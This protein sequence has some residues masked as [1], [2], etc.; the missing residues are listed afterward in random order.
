[1]MR[2][3]GIDRHEW[4]TE[5]E[6]LEDDLHSAP[7]EALP[8]LHDLVERML[9]ARGFALHEDPDD[10]AFEAD[11]LRSFRG[12]HEVAVQVE[13][14]DD[15][16]PGDVGEAIHAFTEIYEQLIDRPDN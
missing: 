7:L 16:D 5:W 15:V 4:Q 8:E 6:A 14:G 9:L 2:E 3:P 13:R 1:M 12:G 11:L 10:G